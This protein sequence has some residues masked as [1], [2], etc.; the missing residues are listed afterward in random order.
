M[1]SKNFS[2]TIFQRKIEFLEEKKL[3]I[4]SIEIFGG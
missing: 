3:N 2:A 1:A 4:L